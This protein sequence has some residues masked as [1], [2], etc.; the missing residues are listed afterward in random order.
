MTRLRERAFFIFQCGVAAALSWYTA[1]TLLGH[2][3]PFFAPVTAIIC[4]GLSFGS[5][6]R[7]VL[8]LMVGVAIGV[9]VGDLFVGMIG[10][11][12]WQIAVVVVLAMSLAAIVGSGQLL[13]TQ[14]GVQASF[15]ATLVAA[16]GQS[17]SRWL[18]AVIGGL[19]AL[20]IALV[21]PR[22]PVLRHSRDV[23][24]VLD[25][26]TPLDHCVRNLRVLVRRAYIATWRD[27]VVPMEYVSLVDALPGPLDGGRP[28]HDHRAGLRRGGRPGSRCHGGR[29]TRW[30]EGDAARGSARSR[31]ESG[32]T[33][34]RRVRPRGDPRRGGRAGR[35]RPGPSPRRPAGSP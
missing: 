29:M 5:R 21:A 1:F 23:R 22:G 4:L 24:E 26:V 19:V 8:E 15:V 16:P 32:W 30:L 14:A 33:G 11:G 35:P 6:L 31:V 3:Q 12:T 9:L 18:D 34:G 2:R 10:A 7:R 27:E 25:L 20:L 28:A 13:T 17:F